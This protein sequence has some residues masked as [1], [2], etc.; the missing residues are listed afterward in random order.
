[1]AN[2]TPI[3][4]FHFKDKMAIKLCG[5]TNGVTEEDLLAMGLTNNRV[6]T[7]IQ[8]NYFE[9]S[10]MK[11]V[12]GKK[13]DFFPLGN[14]GEKYYKENYG[15][16]YSSNSPR[17]DSGLRSEILSRPGTIL[18]NIECWRNEVW[19]RKQFPEIAQLKETSTPDGCFLVDGSLN[20]VEI[21]TEHYSKEQ[22]E[23]KKLFASKLGASLELKKI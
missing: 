15:P 8:N 21:A 4:K 5:D 19:L 14:V 13:I 3:K 10:R 9:K 20:F 23:A 11:I 12:D 22:I 17:H 7:L 6:K 18:D 2:F 1:V 16:L